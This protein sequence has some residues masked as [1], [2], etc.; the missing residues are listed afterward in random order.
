M[1]VTIGHYFY[2]NDVVAIVAFFLIPILT[3]LFI[4]GLGKVFRKLFNKVYYIS[5]GLR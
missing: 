5:T 4:L 1:K 2:K 3:I